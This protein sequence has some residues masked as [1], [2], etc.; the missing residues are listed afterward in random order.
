VTSGVTGVE[1]F[2]VEKEGRPDLNDPK[3]LEWKEKVK[4]YGL[5]SGRLRYTSAHQM[6]SCRMGGDRNRSV[7]DGRGRVWG[8]EGEYC[9]HLTGLELNFIGHVFQIS[10]L[11][12]LP[13]SLR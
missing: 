13:Y 3:Y 4:Q 7:V 2:V 1:D 9:P 8:A 6:G 10:T 12:T 5:T 11:R